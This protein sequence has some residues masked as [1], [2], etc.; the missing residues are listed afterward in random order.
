MK[1][2]TFSGGL[3]SAITLFAT[4]ACMEVSAESEAPPD[5]GDT[6]ADEL[7]ARV[8]TRVADTAAWLD[9]FF[10]TDNYEAESNTTSLRLGVSSFSERGE[11]T[12]VRAKTG[13]RLSLPYLENR[14]RFSFSG[15][16]DDFDTTDSEWEDIDEYVD[17]TDEDSLGAALTYFFREQARRNVSLS[18]GVRFRSGNPGVYVRPRYRQT[19]NVSSW[20]LRFIQRFSWYSDSGL[21]ARSKL[22]AERLLGSD[23]F[24][25]TITQVDWYED[26]DGF[27]PQQNFALIRPF[28][29]KRVLAFHWNNYIKTDPGTVLDST[30]FRLRYRQR[31][32]RSWLWFSVAPQVV[33]PR[34]K[35]Y[36][37]VP[38]IM[39]EIEAWF[40]ETQDAVGRT[41]N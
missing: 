31:I 17:G 7:Q 32:W 34:E 5:T 19:W 41:R 22:Q 29:D 18:G 6:T 23:W 40:R 27:F 35:D 14:L 37:A 8:S 20:D 21:D 13:L 38:G 25:R 12:D 24:F 10:A 28:S 4:L 11:G 26:E 33:F 36:E 30:L 3:A 15:A 1:R 9:S 2:L 39:L 16:T